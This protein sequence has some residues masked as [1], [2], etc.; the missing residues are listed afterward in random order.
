MLRCPFDTSPLPL[1]G[2]AIGDDP[3]MVSIYLHESTA[4]C[5]LWG[6]YRTGRLAFTLKDGTIKVRRERAG[7]C[8]GARHVLRGGAGGGEGRRRAERIMERGIARAVPCRPAACCEPPL[9]HGPHGPHP[10]NGAG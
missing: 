5:L 4:N 6:L 9:L 7:V 2:H 1:P 10:H 8:G 3:A